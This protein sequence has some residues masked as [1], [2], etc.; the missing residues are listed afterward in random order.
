MLL[1]EA[2]AAG[3]LLPPQAGDAARLEDALRLGA[4]RRAAERRPVAAKRRA[5]ERDGARGSRDG[6]TRRRRACRSPSRSRPTWC[7][8]SSTRRSPSGCSATGRST[9]GTR[10]PARCAGWRRGT[11]RREDVD[12]FAADVARRASDD[13]GRARDVDL[14]PLGDVDEQ[15][16]CGRPMSSP[17]RIVTVAG[18]VDQAELAQVG[19]ER[20]G[21]RAGRGIL[22]R[23]RRAGTGRARGSA[24]RARA[25]RAAPSS[26]RARPSARRGGRSRSRGRRAARAWRRRSPGARRRRRRRAAGAPGRG[27]RAPSPAPRGPRRGRRDR[28]STTRGVTLVSVAAMPAVAVAARRRPAPCL[29]PCGR[30]SSPG[31][32]ALGQRDGGRDRGVAAERDLG[33]RA[34][35]AD[36]GSPSQERGSRCSRGRRRSR[37]SR[38][39][40]ARPRRARRPPGCRRRG[41]R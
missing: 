33:E 14:R 11:R 32:V 18:S 35:V 9:S 41:G 10:T 27:R 24:C 3:F 39:R 16:G 6:V 25:R 17:W 28:G 30:R 15:A 38:R 36:V 34:E 37:A 21:G 23:H 12:A 20:G 8:R 1:R 29:R 7:S 2:L 40:T 5:C 26:S 19:A 31:P 13:D 4:A 22:E